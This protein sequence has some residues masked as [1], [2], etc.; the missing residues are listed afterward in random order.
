LNT[1]YPQFASKIS[2]ADFWLLAA[3]TAIQFA[4]TPFK[5]K[6]I[7][8]MQ[9]PPYTLKLPFRYGRKDDVTCSDKGLLP[10]PSFSWKQMTGMFIG[11]IGLTVNQLTAIMGAHSLGRAQKKNSGVEG[12]WTLSQSSLSN[13]FFDS[14]GVVPWTNT[15]HSF[16]WT[17]AGSKPPTMMLRVDVEPLYSP[18]TN[19]PTFDNFTRSGKCHFNHQQGNP[20]ASYLYYATNI[21]G[22]FAN[23]TQGW[24]V[25]SEYNYSPNRLKWVH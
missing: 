12:G 23:F 1:L 10:A 16:V 15:N 3:N 5:G 11:R 13:G 18:A 6:T 21:Q 4:T 14:L 8:G 19:C 22:F 7:P 9:P 24:Q 25:L 20:S 2:K 17:N